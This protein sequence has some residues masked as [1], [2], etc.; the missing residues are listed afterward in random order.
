MRK[1]VFS[2]LLLAIVGLLCSSAGKRPVTLFMVGD[3]TMADKEELDISPE[4]GWGQLFPTYLTGN[5]VVENHARNG[6]STKSFIAQE[7]WAEVMNRVKK[8]DIVLIQFGHNDAKQSD[9]ER[10]TPIADY[11]KNLMQMISEAQ[12]KKAHVIQ[13]NIFGDPFQVQCFQLLRRCGTPCGTTD[14]CA[15]V[16]H[17]EKYGRV[18]DQPRRRT[19]QTILYERGSGRVSQISRRQ[20]RQHALARSRSIGSRPPSSGATESIGLEMDLQIYYV[21]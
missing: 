15:F 8:G 21:G 1:T 5:I 2:V 12:K 4:R 13:R 14:E 9:P 19:K 7:R 11:E 16:G 17:G 20:D 3:S 6:R 18:A 10:Y